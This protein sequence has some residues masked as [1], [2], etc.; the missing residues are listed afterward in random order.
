MPLRLNPL[1]SEQPVNRRLVLSLVIFGASAGA[2]F[3]AL[4]ITI[5]GLAPRL[6]RLINE[7]EHLPELGTGMLFAGAAVYLLKQILD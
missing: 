7:T 4:I 2:S 6:A 5:Q 1:L 3:V